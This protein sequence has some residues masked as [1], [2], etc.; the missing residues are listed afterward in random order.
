MLETE[1]GFGEY[2]GLIGSTDTK[3]NRDLLNESGLFPLFLDRN[4]G[5]E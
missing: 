1:M 3:Q 4:L 5:Y 2:K